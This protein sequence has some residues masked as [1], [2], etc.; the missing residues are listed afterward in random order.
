VPKGYKVSP[1]RTV[2]TISTIQASRSQCPQGLR[3]ESAAD[4]FLGLRVRLPPGGTNVCLFWVLC[5]FW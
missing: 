5:I 1:S 4:S 2:H 3:R